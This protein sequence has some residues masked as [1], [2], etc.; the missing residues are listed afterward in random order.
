V[1]RF[2]PAER[3]RSGPRIARHVLLLV[4][5]FS[6]SGEVDCRLELTAALVARPKTANLPLTWAF[7]PFCG[8]QHSAA[9][10]TNV[11]QRTREACKL[12]PVRVM[13]LVSANVSYSIQFRRVELCSDG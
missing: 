8:E 11:E 3:E 1:L 7:G 9:L 5:D 4:S 2:F 13:P 6:P 12:Q 10:R